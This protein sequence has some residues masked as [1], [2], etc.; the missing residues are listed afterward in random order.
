MKKIIGSIVFLATVLTLLIGCNS[1]PSH[2]QGG[3][4]TNAPMVEIHLPEGVVD[5]TVDN[6]IILLLNE[7]FT[8]N[9][10]TSKFEIIS[11]DAVIVSVNGE[12]ADS[13][14][15]WNCESNIV[16]NVRLSNDAADSG[17]F[18]L[19]V[20]AAW[21]EENGLSDYS[22]THSVA[23]D[24]FYATKNGKIAFSLKSES[25]ALEKLN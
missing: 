11:G 18:K 23:K 8:D 24:V 1:T 10:L 7:D 15:E 3:T 4:S 19:F 5:S 2:S 20:T 25:D 13:T 16:L 9:N 21:V 14:I 12:D 17:S 22:L 6:E